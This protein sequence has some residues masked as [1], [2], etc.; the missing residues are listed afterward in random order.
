MAL[1]PLHIEFAEEIATLTER[2]TQMDGRMNRI[3]LKFWALIA[4]QGATLLSIII[5]LLSR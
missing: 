3:D 2:S 5:M 4:G 1:C